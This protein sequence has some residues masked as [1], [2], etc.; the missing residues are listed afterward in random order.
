MSQ[1]KDAEFMTAKEKELVLKQWRTFLKNYVPGD[2]DHIDKHFS[3]K[4]Y[5][6]LIYHC[7][8][9]AHYN[10]HMFIS[11]YFNDGDSA[12]RFFRQFDSDYKYQSAEIAMNNWY[13]YEPY[14]DLNSAICKEFDKVKEK[15]YEANCVYQENKDIQMAEMLLKKH[16]KLNTATKEIYVHNIENFVGEK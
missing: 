9:I 13:Y 16:G 4:L 7:S 10:R 2:L 11:F 8:F 6:H 5:E 3:K 15:I 12:M 14:H 1:F